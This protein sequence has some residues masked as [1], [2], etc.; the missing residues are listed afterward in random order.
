MGDG[1]FFIDLVDLPQ[2]DRDYTVF[3][4]VAR[5]MEFVDRLLEGAKIVSVSVK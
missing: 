5:G 3:A 2:F 1:Q 4:Y